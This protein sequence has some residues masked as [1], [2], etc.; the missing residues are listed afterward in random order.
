MTQQYLTEEGQNLQ[1]LPPMPVFPHQAP[2]VPFTKTRLFLI[3]LLVAA[4]LLGAGVSGA[5]AVATATARAANC[6]VAFEYADTALDA[7]GNV[8]GYL[9]D[10]LK[11]AARLDADALGELAPKIDA[12]NSRL[13]GL[14]EKYGAAR[15]L[16]EK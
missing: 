9:G 16:C 6:K 7:S 11:S 8:I 15:D 12:E 4:V 5:F 10:G 3:L 13:D 1:S 2:K 14:P